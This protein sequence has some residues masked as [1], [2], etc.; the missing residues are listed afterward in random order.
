M[1]VYPGALWGGNV[2]GTF[3]D[4]PDIHEKWH[5]DVQNELKAT[6]A[7]LGTQP[8]GAAATVAARFT[9]LDATVAA[10]AALA[11]ATFTGAIS[12]TTGSFSGTVSGAT[13]TVAAHLTRKDYVDAADAL[14]LNLTGGTVTGQI[15]GITPTSAAHLTRKDYVDL[16]AL[17]SGDTFSGD[18]QIGGDA[19]TRVAG[20]DARID[21]VVISAVTNTAGGTSSTANYTL[22]REGLAAGQPGDVGGVM[23]S[24]RRGGTQIGGAIIAAG[25]GTTWATTSDYRMKE[26]EGPVEG[27]LD[28]IDR[29]RPFR[30]R[31][32]EKPNG[33]QEIMLMAHEEA[34]VAPWAVVG[35]KDAVEKD[36]SILP[37]MDDKAKLVPILIAGIQELRREIKSL[38]KAR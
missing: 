30:G 18:V 19:E 22:H 8:S 3:Q 16:R 7:E 13:P 27:A 12:G 20:V 24:C 28:M 6:Q 10:K 14:K 34:E 1:A 23:I 31:W 25:P 29:F 35:E 2:R 11:G 4:D 33:P 21:G 36:G 38:K 9:A 32:K 17:K 15:S 37:Q 5:D 26:D